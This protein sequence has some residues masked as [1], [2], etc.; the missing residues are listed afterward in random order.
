MAH[1]P[2]QYTLPMHH[3]DDQREDSYEVYPPTSHYMTR[4][5]S[6][7]SSGSSFIKKPPLMSD[8]ALPEPPPP[9]KSKAEKQ[10]ELAKRW[11]TNLLPHSWPIRLFLATVVVETIVDLAVQ[12][13]MYSRISSIPTSDPDLQ[14]AVR[15]VILYL[16]LFAFAHIFQFLLA[17]EAVWQQ[18]T[19]Q[20]LFLTIFNLLFFIYSLVEADEIRRLGANLD[21]GITSISINTLTIISHVI[22]G[23]A[24]IAYV[25]LGWQIWKEFGWK[26]YKFLGADRQIKRIFFHYQIFLSLLRFDFYF[27]VGFS[28]Q[29]VYFI[30]QGK[31]DVEYFL[32]IAAVPL[33]ILLL[34]AGH[35]AARKENKYLMFAFMLGCVC[36]AVYFAYKLF[37]IY[38]GGSDSVYH[39]V[40]K[41]LTLFAAVSLFFL[42]VT[43]IW[44]CIVMHN[45][46]RGLKEQ[47]DKGHAMG[48][49]RRA[50]SLTLDNK[51][52]PM[53]TNP[54]RM[55]I[56]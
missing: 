22:L 55:S 16:A 54:N 6:H 4:S 52:F 50:T 47:M 48:H 40:A 46:N 32:T 25:A 29:L 36:A 23:V 45:F 49:H 26:V 39:P 35:F 42:I 34:I 11:T 10:A 27:C 44:G 43:F 3:D 33:G 19:L 30:L 37:R 15:R 18:N 21:S 9:L 17:I 1:N 56:E 7:H 14:Q 5:S 28:A 51:H 13:D 24:E 8:E 31:N 2:S 20:F 53:S 41:S 38:D 12:G